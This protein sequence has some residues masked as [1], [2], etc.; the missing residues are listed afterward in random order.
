MDWTLLPHDCLM[1]IAYWIT[2][3]GGSLF[4]LDGAGINASVLT[5]PP[6][7]RLR[8]TRLNFLL[9][10]E[11]IA[12]VCRAWRDGVDWVAVARGLGQLLKKKAALHDLPLVHDPALL[13]GHVRRMLL[14]APADRTP[15]L[16]VRA[17]SAEYRR[18]W[19]PSLKA[20]YPYQRIVEQVYLGDV[21]EK[22]RW[23]TWLDA[24]LIVRP[25][26]R[27]G[28]YLL[29]KRRLTLDTSLVT[30]AQV[31]AT[32][33]PLPADLRQRFIQAP[34]EHL[35]QVWH[36]YFLPGLAAMGCSAGAGWHV[37]QV[38]LRHYPE[39]LRTETDLVHRLERWHADEAAWAEGE[40]EWR[41]AV[42]AARRGVK[43]RR[44]ATP[45]GAPPAKRRR[46]PS[47]PGPAPAAAWTT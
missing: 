38:G 29:I 1:Q 21:E 33:P 20:R 25:P 10:F 36:E 28:R 37:V 7:Q 46:L 44:R 12:H 18:T 15:F 14:D 9:F 30:L 17:F 3:R 23:R 43:R 35:A 8:E 24:V 40:R 22:A 13:L 45:E 31:R 19:Y 11:R 26:P 47:P 42:E 41:A 32:L 27:E 16:I 39:M 2:G 34:L 5:L 6:R 4:A